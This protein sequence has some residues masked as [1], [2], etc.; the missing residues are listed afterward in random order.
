MDY[1]QRF[2]T[3]QF[4]GGR[5]LELARRLAVYSGICLFLIAVLVLAVLWSCRSQG[6]RPY[7]LY[8]GGS[9]GWAVAS[10]RVGA[11]ALPWFHILQESI[12]VRHI[13]D[14]FRITGDQAGNEDVLWC[15][16]GG[17]ECESDFN[18]CRICCA[19]APRAFDAFEH[20]VLPKLRSRFGAGD[21]MELVNITARPAGRISESNGVWEVAGDLT[22]RRRARIAAFVRIDR[23]QGRER[24]VGY[25]V[26]EVNFYRE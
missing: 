5:P 14:Y 23:G 20:G 11:S 16:C 17:G 9:G 10:E 4:P 21:T 2:F 7:F 15:R 22:G 3:R 6:V 26:S 18:R 1:P 13:A 24:T 19:S 12:A 8:A 25:Q